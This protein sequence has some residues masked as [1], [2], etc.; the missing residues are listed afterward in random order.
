VTPRHLSVALVVALALTG[1]ACSGDG[2]TTAATTE[3]SAPTTTTIGVH[4]VPDD[5][6]Q[7][8]VQRVMDELDA[9]WG[10]MFRQFEL[11]GEITDSTRT[12]IE[13]LHGD[14][15]TDM[16]AE[17]QGIADQGF[18]IAAE[19]PGDPTTAVEEIIETTA[20]CVVF[21]ARRSYADVLVGVESG[22][23]TTHLR[24]RRHDGDVDNRKNTTAWVLRDE[25]PQDDA[26]TGEEE[27][28]C[29]GT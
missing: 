2:D 23:D 3:T 15:A 1:T 20:Q 29:D 11:D 7:E 27:L 19:S 25:V 21:S 14:S 4:E 5:I 10:G 13:S 18:D 9:S 24:L 17:L 12:W 28:S 16:V 22:D 8:Y 26:S 6:T